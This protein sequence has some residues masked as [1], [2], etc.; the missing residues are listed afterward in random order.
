MHQNAPSCRIRK[1]WLDGA[2]VA[3]IGQ[4]ADLTY[5][6]EYYGEGGGALGE[7]LGGKSELLERLRS[8]QRPAVLVGPGILRR[9]D[10]GAV[11]QQVGKQPQLPLNMKACF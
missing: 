2:E 6:Y 4:K 5:P 3:V 10:R 8:A 11:M 7:A 9:P 1:C